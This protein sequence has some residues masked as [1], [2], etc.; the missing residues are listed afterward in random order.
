MTINS[1]NA[2]RCES[3]GEE[4]TA[5]LY[6]RHLFHP[7]NPGLSCQ[8]R[9]RKRFIEVGFSRHKR[10]C[11]VCC[12]LEEGLCKL[13]RITFNFIWQLTVGMPC[14]EN[15]Q[16]EDELWLYSGGIL[17]TPSILGFLVGGGGE[18]VYWRWLLP[19]QKRLLCLLK[20]Q[21]GAL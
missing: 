4:W 21:R 14:I 9:R 12:P 15:P 2:M 17:S 10:D 11:C 13:K 8:R 19:T 6:R 7:F 16:R 20:S 3:P 1:G 18:K 5:T